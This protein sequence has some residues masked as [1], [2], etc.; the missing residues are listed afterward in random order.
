[1]N[2]LESAGFSRA[3]PYYIVQQGKVQE[4]AMMKGSERLELLKDVAGTKVYDERREESMKIMSDADEKMTKIDELIEAIDERLDELAEEKS[5]LEQYQT[6]DKE[7]KSLEYTLLDKQLN[8]TISKM[9]EVKQIIII[10]IIINSPFLPP[11]P[12]QSPR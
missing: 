10:I 2:L 11:S 1:M 12:R 8:D 6:L 3:N 5:E 4:L 7:R 9:T